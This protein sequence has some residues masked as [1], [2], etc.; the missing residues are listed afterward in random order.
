MEN[1]DRTGQ[2]A[3]FTGIMNQLVQIGRDCSVQERIADI[4]SFLKRICEYICADRV[5]LY[6]SIS[7]GVLGRTFVY[8]RLERPLD[9]E[10]FI[11]FV[12]QEIPEWYTKFMNG[13]SVVIEDREKIREERP[14]EYRALK[15]R[16]ITG[17]IAIPILHKKLFGLIKIDDPDMEKT[18]EFLP[19]LSL[20][21]AYL[22]SVRL[23]NQKEDILEQHQIMLQDN[24]VK[25]EQEREFLDVLCRDFTSVY[26]VDLQADT[27]EPLKLD[28]VANA[29]RYENLTKRSTQ[30]YTQMMRKYCDEFVVAGQA[31]RF[32]KIMSIENLSKELQHKERIIFRYRSVPNLKQQQYFETQVIR[33]SEEDFD[34]KVLL[35][36]RHVDDLVATEQRRQR[37]LEETLEVVRQSNEVLT[38][39]GK[40]YYAIFRIDLINDVYEEIS[41]DSEVHHLTGKSGQAS[42]EMMELCDAFVVPQ[43]RDRIK[44]FFDLS[45]LARRLKNDETIASEYLAMDGNWHTARFIAKRRDKN[46]EVTHVLYVTRLISDIKRREQNWIAIAEE[47][48]RANDAKTEFISQVAH[49]IR[50]PMNA[51]MGFTEIISANLD[52][53][54]KVKYG[55]EKIKVSGEF[56][57]E[58]VEEVL[59]ISK[60][61]NGQMKLHP[62]PTSIRSLAEEFGPAVAHSRKNN[63]IKFTCNLHD[64]RHER[65]IVDPLRLQQ[66]YANV[67]SNA[68]KYTPDGGCVELE[69]Y[70]E[71]AEDPEKIRLISIIRDTGIG[72]SEEYMKKM[73]SKFS[74]ETDTRINKVNGHGLGLSIVKELTDLMG[75]RIDVKSRQGLGTTFRLTFEFPYEKVEM[76]K[77][78]ISQDTDYESICQGM[79]VLVAEDNDLNM[80]VLREL[81]A[82]H[83][84]TCDWA[85]DGAICVEKFRI[86]PSAAYDAILMDI[87]M[88]VMNG[89]EATKTIR[90]LKHPEACKIPIIAMT[91]NAFRDDVEKCLDAGMN[92]HM[93]KP[94]DIQKLL[95]T[96]AMYVR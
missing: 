57:Q 73:Y 51:I 47:A 15:A 2:K 31:E 66:I 71:Q 39:I 41:S 32:I 67:L 85:E 10:D 35:G 82:M 28:Q 24:R 34:Y 53:K 76:R 70:E 50:T 4:N 5:A 94:V 87:Q 23:N 77:E 18:G 84:I 26:Y 72:M 55:L 61:E 58:L 49:D 92:A 6:E 88:P 93:S 75:G 52:N 89:L 17:V 30:C 40:I 19:V 54:E 48:N 68:M 64:M 90:N 81:L 95:K 8:D 44:Q 86:A 60:I 9:D 13:E 83:R 11:F 7:E 36:F 69:I 78:A 20:I 38:A 56:L 12:E 43:Y 46:G 96:L 79:H 27:L 21:G 59:D 22:A 25:L 3:D 74:R 29:A 37:E 42:T 65:L 91:A 33:I 62:E 14:S 80:E 16:G 63:G 1:E 45:T